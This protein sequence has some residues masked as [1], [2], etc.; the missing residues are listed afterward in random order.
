VA[1]AL[2]FDEVIFV[3]AN[4]P[5][6][7]TGERE[8]TPAATRLEMTRAL[9]D[10]YENFSVDDREIRRGG[11]TYTVDTLNELH[12][13]NLDAEIFLIVGADTA[14]RIHTWHRYE[15][16]LSLSTLVVVN[17]SDAS[18]T[19][20]PELAQAQ[21]ELVS[22]PAVDVSSTQIRDAVAQGSSI[23]GMT[24]AGVLSVIDAQGLYTEVSA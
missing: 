2:S 16:V 18:S 3:V 20:A 19:L 5:W 21:V 15:D 8:V 10:G 17:R 1:S 13:E 12:Q 4:D 11:P 14:S 6:Q 7:K 9:V 24:T 23:E 22:M